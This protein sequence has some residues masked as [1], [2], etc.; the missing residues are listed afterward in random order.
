MSL[1]PTIVAAIIAAVA[2]LLGA[3]LS[4][5]PERTSL[6]RLERIIAVL[7]KVQDPK[8]KA[9]LLALRN[10]LIDEV[11]PSKTNRSTVSKAGIALDLGALIPIAVSL[12]ILTL[13]PGARLASTIVMAFAYLAVAASIVLL[14]IGG[15]SEKR[16][17]QS[18]L[19]T[20]GP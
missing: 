15:V 5:I 20:W 16:R 19:D 9:P 10:R 2:L 13:G 11:A 17:R 14:I 18:E 8:A 4:R 12:F 6:R 7:E 3:V 1:A